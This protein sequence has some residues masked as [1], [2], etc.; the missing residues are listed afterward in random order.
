MA[1]LIA[2]RLNSECISISS[3]VSVLS[4]KLVGWSHQNTYHAKNSL[5]SFCI[6]QSLVYLF[7]ISANNFNMQMIL[8]QGIQNLYRWPKVS[9][10]QYY[11]YFHQVLHILTSPPSYSTYAHLPDEGYSLPTKISDNTKFSPFFN[12]ARRCYRWHT[13][14]LCAIHWGTTNKS[15]LE[16][17]DHTECRRMLFIQP[18]VSVSP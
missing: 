11:R 16:G 15:Q 3:K 14:Q 7:D 8:F 6:A 13:H 12:N 10:D 4:F 9:L 2:S 18:Q 17:G 1:T 5:Q